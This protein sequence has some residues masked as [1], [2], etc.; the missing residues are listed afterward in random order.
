MVPV[1][2]KGAMTRTLSEFHDAELV[3][4]EANRDERSL[5][6]KFRRADASI[7]TLHVEGVSRFR[8]VDF[9]DQ[10]VVSRLL[11]SSSHAFSKDEIAYWCRWIC[12]LSDTTSWADEGHIEEVRSKIA[13]GKLLLLVLEPSCGAE[14]AALGLSYSLS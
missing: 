4:L 11:V 1:D 7:S 8:I 2:G 3:G 14:L 10:N 5:T 12:T 6:L 13:E 9:V